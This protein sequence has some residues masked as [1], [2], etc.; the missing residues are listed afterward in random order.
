MNSDD[1]KRYQLLQRENGNSS[2][3]SHSSIQNKIS[4][5]YNE[6]MYIKEVQ[7]LMEDLLKKQRQTICVSLFS[8]MLNERDGEKIFEIFVEV[9]LGRK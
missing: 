1:I 7:R 6:S 8:Y 9:S 4:Y 3:G 2:K 5:M